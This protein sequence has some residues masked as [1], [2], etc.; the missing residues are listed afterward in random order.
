[1][2]TSP[3]SPRPYTV[4]SVETVAETAELTAKRFVLAPGQ[5]IPW[6]FHLTIT[7]WFYCLEGT[8]KVETRAPR[9]THVMS[10][11]G[12]CAVPPRTAH[13]VSNAGEVRCCYLILQGVGAYDYIPV[14]GG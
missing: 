13:R 12:S 1:M 8:L 14:G 7:D 3:S 2:S 9:G 10:P 5:E 4:E 11:G 6:H